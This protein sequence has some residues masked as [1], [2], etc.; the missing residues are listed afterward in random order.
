MLRLL[1]FLFVEPFSKLGKLLAHFLDL[2]VRFGALLGR[3]V[4]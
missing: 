4:V 3:L 2:F 1:R